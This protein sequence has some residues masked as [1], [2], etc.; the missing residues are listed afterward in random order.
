MRW[1]LWSFIT[2]GLCYFLDFDDTELCVLAG[3]TPEAGLQ[4]LAELGLY[5]I[6]SWKLSCL[7]EWP[8]LCVWDGEWPASGWAAAHLAFALFW[9]TTPIFNSHVSPQHLPFPVFSLPPLSQQPSHPAPRTSLASKCTNTH[10]L[11]TF[12]LK[13]EKPFF[14]PPI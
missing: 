3:L 1:V 6:S 7:P 11:H 9:R 14:Q 10:I 4:S 8:C 5:Q 12:S 2:V 13:P